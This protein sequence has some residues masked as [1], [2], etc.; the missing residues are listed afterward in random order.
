MNVAREIC[1][2]R[3][4]D[5]LPIKVSTSELRMITRE[6]DQPI[7]LPCLDLHLCRRPLGRPGNINGLNT[8]CDVLKQDLE[9]LVLVS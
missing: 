6:P 7:S 5:V 2:S 8:F 1:L 9:P 3:P 4:P